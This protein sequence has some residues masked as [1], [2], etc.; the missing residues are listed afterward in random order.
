MPETMEFSLA[1]PTERLVVRE[2]SQVLIPG[3]EGDMTVM[4]GHEPLVA[5]LRPGLLVADGPDGET[6]HVV[7]GGFVQI[8]A[9][10]TSVLA[11]DAAAAEKLPAGWI[12]GLEAEFAAAAENSTG[13]TNDAAVKAAAE[14]KALRN[15]LKV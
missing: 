6:R 9:R 4:P 13:A 3:S 1:C 14:L 10:R 11:D 5:A 12:D 2:V 15:K 8:T 7:S